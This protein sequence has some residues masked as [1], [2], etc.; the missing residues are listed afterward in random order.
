MILPDAMIER[1][2]IDQMMIESYN[3]GQLSSASYDLALGD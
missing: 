2:I 3:E 1:R